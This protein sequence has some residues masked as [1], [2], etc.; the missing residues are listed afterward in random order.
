MSSQNAGDAFEDQ[1]LALLQSAGLRL[2][3]RNW[4][5]RFGEIDLIM[6]EDATLIFVEVRKRSSARFGGAAASISAAKIE[7]LRTSASMYLAQ[8]RT[9]PACRIDAIV[10]ENGNHAAPQWLKNIV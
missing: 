9:S 1:A 5:C 8:M 10:F 6:K 4:Q 7:K 2:I 3:A